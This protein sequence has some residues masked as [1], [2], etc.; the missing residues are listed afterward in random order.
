MPAKTDN[1]EERGRRRQHQSGVEAPAAAPPDRCR[2][3]SSGVPPTGSRRGGSPRPDPAGGPRIQRRDARIRP[4]R[5]R[6][7]TGGGKQKATTMR[8]TREQG[9]PYRWEPVRFDRLPVKP[10]RSG[11]GLGRYQ[12][13]PNSKFKF[14]FQKIKKFSK[15]S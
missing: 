11:S 12:T 4:Q 6:P 10:V 5:R 2:G 8:S 1:G 7:V 3:A 9:S 15:N 14:K 13:G